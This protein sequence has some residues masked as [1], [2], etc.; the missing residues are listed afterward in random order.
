MNNDMLV[1][2]GVKGMKWGVRKKRESAKSKT[3]GRGRY[4]PDEIDRAFYGKRGAQRIA[5]RRNKGD[6]HLVASLKE[7]ARQLVTGTAL[8]VAMVAGLG[9][10][11][12]GKGAVDAYYNTT[13]FNRDGSVARKYHNG[14]SVGKEVVTSLV[15][16]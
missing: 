12:S 3:S 14:F 6:S 11:S 15:K 5:E 1:H 4:A 8:A 2:Y 10:I 7:E 16:K 9:I 13:I